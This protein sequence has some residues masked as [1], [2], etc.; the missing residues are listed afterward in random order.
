ML[1]QQ[2]SDIIRVKRVGLGKQSVL[3]MRC[4][5]CCSLCLH[6]YLSTR[7]V[8]FQSLPATPPISPSSVAATVATPKRVQVPV[9][10]ILKAQGHS[11]ITS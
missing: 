1:G 5:F 10:Y 11:H 7:L 9:W 2:I 8:W 3:Q 4:F 6:S